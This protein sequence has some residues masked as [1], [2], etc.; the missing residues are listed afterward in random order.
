[1]VRCAPLLAGVH[2]TEPK[3]P[4]DDRRALT[5]VLGR[6]HELIAVWNA[7]RASVRLTGL[8]MKRARF[9]E[10]QVI[11][12]L[13]A[14]ETSGNI[15]SS[16]AEHNIT[17]QTFYRWRRKYGGIEVSEAK[18]L[19]E[20]ERENSDLKKTWPIDVAARSTWRRRFRRANDAP[21]RSQTFPAARSVV[22][23]AIC[24]TS[25]WQAQYSGPMRRGQHAAKRSASRNGRTV[26]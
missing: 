23:Q 26:R 3:P 22:S 19:K 17:E 25:K 8:K 1:M 9:S 21:A 11:G 16:C 5:L 7:G 6:P 13:K 20:L 24:V 12:I 2:S 18:K 10:E 14:A 15:R 4:A